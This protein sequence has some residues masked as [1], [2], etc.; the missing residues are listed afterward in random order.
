MYVAKPS[1]IRLSHKTSLALGTL[2]AGSLVLVPSIANADPKPTVEQVQ[3]QLNKLYQQ[4][5]D[6]NESYNAAQVAAAQLQT[7]L[8]GIHAKTA[9]EQTAIQGVQNQIGGMAAAQ[10]RAGGG[11]DPTMQMLMQQDPKTTLE[12]A[13]TVSRTSSMNATAIA[14]YAQAKIQL[15]AQGRDAADKLAQLDKSAKEAAAQKAEFDGDVANAQ[16][17][18]ASL[19][20][21]Q[22]QQ[23][24]ALQAQQAAGALAQAQAANAAAAAK[25]TS[26]AP[27]GTATSTAPS[28]T[29]TTAP[30]SG[31]ATTAPSSGPARAL[32]NAAPNARSAAAVAF[33]MAQIGKPYIFGGTGPTGYDCSGLTMSAWKAVGVSIPRTATAQ[34]QGLSA[35][36]ASAA[37]PGDLVFFYG[38]SSYVNHVGM[39]IGNGMVVHASRP[40]EPISTAP[41]SSMPAVSYARP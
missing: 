10:Y 22:R 12:M 37:E 11:L 35:V 26:T 27:S 4:A 5:A 21:E 33:A 31:T 13:A 23:L 7:Q 9:E 18:L 2:V 15:D 8:D 36:S 38:N 39:Y 28:D 20:G 32:A 14:T 25:A 41:V 19:Q 34:M 3:V 17:L 29:A 16:Q 30:S 40:G 24:A 6:A 1:R